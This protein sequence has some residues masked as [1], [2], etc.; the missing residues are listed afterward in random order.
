MNKQDFINLLKDFKKEIVAV[1]KEC[2]SAK[3]RQVQTKELL[4]KLE[5]LGVVW[6]DKI[7]SGLRAQY[8][9][10][11]EITGKYRDLFGRVLEIT[12]G[13]PSKRIVQELLDKLTENYH[14]DLV[15]PVQKHQAIL[16]EF[17]QLQGLFTAST[18][19]EKEYLIEAVECARLK[20]RRA[21]V[22]LGWCAAVDRLHSY[23]ERKGF[24]E[25]NSAS[26]RM[27]NITKGRYKRFNKRFEVHNL[28]DLRMTIFDR[29][30]LWVLE[31]M[32]AIDSNEHERLG[33][34]LTMRDTSAHPGQATLSDENV[35]SFFSD[36][37]RMIFS[38]PRFQMK[39]DLMGD[40]Q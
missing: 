38:N 34:C 10:D 16:S 6:F 35:L 29:D 15:V 14:R 32:G 40:D 24:E 8:D 31:F 5:K 3:G 1:S 17:Q 39:D 9:I 7:E 11:D 4:G 12:G 28:S 33:I 26:I 20:K 37:D 27:A 2:Q 25:F 30:L 13:R 22:I 21:A 36:I 19:I 18:D 23:V